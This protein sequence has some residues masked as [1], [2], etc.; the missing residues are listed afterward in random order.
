MNSL[1]L[2]FDYS[3]VYELLTQIQFTEIWP[4]GTL[5]MLATLISYFGITQD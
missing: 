2:R 3:L 1:N 4:T 5:Q